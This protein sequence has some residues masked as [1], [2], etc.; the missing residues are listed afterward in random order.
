M[1]SSISYTTLSTH[2]PLQ[3]DINELVT[4]FLHLEENALIQHLFNGDSDKKISALSTSIEGVPLL[5]HL[6]MERSDEFCAAL[7]TSFKATDVR[8]QLK[9]IYDGHRRNPLQLA[10]FSEKAKTCEALLD[11]YN[12]ERESLILHTDINGYNA[13]RWAKNAAFYCW[14]L[15]FISDEQRHI[16]IKG[17]LATYLTHIFPLNPST[18]SNN[19]IEENASSLVDTCLRLNLPKETLKAILDLIPWPLL[20]SSLEDLGG[21]DYVLNYGAEFCT[22]IIEKCPLNEKESLIQGLQAR[23]EILMQSLNESA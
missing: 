17:D 22:M 12:E 18:L 4:L 13:F 10:L 14:L 3:K 8:L 20:V 5:F 16:Q 15:P 7:I 19:F 23:L 6:L 2:Y 21:T 1:S 9:E 11:L